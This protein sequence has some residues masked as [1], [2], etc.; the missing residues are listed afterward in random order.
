[1]ML[2]TPIIGLNHN[3]RYIQNDDLFGYLVNDFMSVNS[4]ER[5]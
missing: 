4:P 1:M 3:K 2:V 5:K